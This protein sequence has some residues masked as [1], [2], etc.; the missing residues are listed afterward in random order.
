VIGSLA[1]ALD[2]AKKD[3][4]YITDL[5]LDKPICHLDEYKHIIEMITWHEEE[6]IGLEVREFNQFILDKWDW[7][8]NFLS[9]SSVYSSSSSSSSSSALITR[10]MSEL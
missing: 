4:E 1:I 9:T 7:Q 6:I 10:K 8:Y 3:K 2:R 5:D